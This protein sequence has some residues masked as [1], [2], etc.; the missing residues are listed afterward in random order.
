ME[1]TIKARMQLKQS[2][3]ASQQYKGTI[4]GLKKIVKE[5]GLAGLYKGITFSISGLTIGVTPKLTQSVLNAAFLF[6]F[7]EFFY[8]SSK[9]VM[10]L[11]RGPKALDAIKRK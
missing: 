3:D 8:N 2:N 7:K 10:Q 6:M 5:E 9:A 11:H 4:A 1:V